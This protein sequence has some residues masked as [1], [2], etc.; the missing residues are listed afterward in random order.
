MTRP[1]DVARYLCLRY[2]RNDQEVVGALYLDTR[3]RLIREREVFRGTLNR[4]AVE[5]RGVL[6]EAVLQGA[7]GVVLFHTHPSGDPSPSR[8]DLLFSRQLYLAGEALG[9]PLLDHLIIGSPQR[10][11]SLR[12]RGW[13]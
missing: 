10:W 7:A 1:E 3:N 4:A 11:T 9:I 13:R 6:K 2:G 5:P 8:E 12:E